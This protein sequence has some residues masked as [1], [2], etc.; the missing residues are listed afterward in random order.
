[1]ST[2][3]SESLALG[4][5]ALLVG[6]LSFGLSHVSGRPRIGFD[7]GHGCVDC[8]TQLMG[9]VTHRMMPA[10]DCPRHALKQLSIVLVTIG[11]QIEIGRDLGE[12]FVTNMLDVALHKIIV[13]VPI[14]SACAHGGLLDTSRNL[15]RMK[16]MK[17]EPIDHR[18]LDFVMQDEEAV[19]FDRSAPLF[20][21][22]RHM[23]V[24]VNDST[25]DA[26]AGKVW[27]IVFAVELFEASDDRVKRTL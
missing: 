14:D 24:D 12:T 4:G 27:N 2:A 8:R 3:P 20:E 10:L 9:T 21:R 19:R 15:M 18:F 26:V 6:G 22:R 13:I 23:A 25:V 16:V 5:P 17:I 11:L 1:M 7:L